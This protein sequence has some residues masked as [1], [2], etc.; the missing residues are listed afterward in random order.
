[1]DSEYFSFTQ[2][3]STFD[4]FGTLG[5]DDFTNM[6][7]S[8][9]KDYWLIFLLSIIL[10]YL[11]IKLYP[12]AK[13]ELPLP[14][15]NFKNIL[16]KSLIFFFIA[17]LNVASI[18]GFDHRPIAITS[19]A[20]FSSP[21][22]VSLTL[23]TP[24]TI[25]KTLN[26]E[27][28]EYKSYFNLKKQ[29]T[30][31]SPIKQ[32]NDSVFNK[33]NVVIIIL[34]SFGKDYSALYHPS[35]KGFM[36]FLDSLSK[37]SLFFQYSFA[38][39]QRSMEALPSILNSSPSLMNKP[40]ITSQYASN[41]TRGLASVLKNEGYYT[42]FMHG[43]SNGTMDFDKFCYMSGFLDYYGKNEYPNPKDYDGNWGIFDE[44]YLLYSIDMMD[45]F[46]KPFLNTI[47]TLSSHH[48]YKIPE[49][50]QGV[51]PEGKLE[52]HKSVAYADHALKVFFN[53]A[54]KTDWYNNTLFVITADHTSQSTT[55]YYF[56]QMG[57]YAVPI[58]F[59]APN[60]STIN[61]HS[62]KIAQHIDIMPSILDY[63]G[64]SKP[65]YSFGSSLF[66]DKRE[67]FYVN[68]LNDRY[69]FAKGDFACTFYDEE[70]HSI[71]QWKSDSTL[72]K[73]LIKKGNIKSEFEKNQL[74][75]LKSIIQT[76]NNDLID[77]KAFVNS[78]QQ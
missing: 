39:G 68:F 34:E 36:P 13:T 18:R 73:N 66:N 44:P 16:K 46:K 63:L 9:L 6:L 61:K 23:N 14:V 45:R 15:Y 28:L 19:A 4:I 74:P 54:K 64:Y 43:G 58:I 38:N 12:R 72:R 67:N 30:L 65:F 1:M 56:S 25:L 27:S 11:I 5:N 33:K 78:K 32:Y 35:R 71:Y 21:Q 3:R 59:F 24:F 70:V 8:Y 2:K 7:G 31:F 40:Y 17:A 62:K 60:D 55:S 48:P 49:Q 47:F 22:T 41:K 69:V 42:S 50:Y 52:I 26:K 53:K 51:F 20:K 75:Y 77:N 76:Y 10:T 57:N 29:Q 37:S